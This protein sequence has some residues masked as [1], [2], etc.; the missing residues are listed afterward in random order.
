[1]ELFWENYFNVDVVHSS[2]IT[3]ALSTLYVK[4]VREKFI[5]QKKKGWDSWGF[6]AQVYNF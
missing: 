5:E 3:C 2:E 1:M 4:D 6:P